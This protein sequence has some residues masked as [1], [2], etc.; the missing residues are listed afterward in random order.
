MYCFPDCQ[1]FGLRFFDQPECFDDIAGFHSMVLQQ[2]RSAISFA[3][4]YDHLGAA[5]Y[6]VDVRRR[7][8]PWREQ[9]AY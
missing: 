7:M 9:N 1:E 4:P 8:L 2:L 5:L 3:E 6:H